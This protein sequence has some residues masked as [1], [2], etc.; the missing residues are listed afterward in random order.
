[1]E[2]STQT[3]E[4]WYQ[5]VVIDKEWGLSVRCGICQTP[6]T[7]NHEKHSFD[8]ACACN[9]NVELRGATLAERPSDRRERT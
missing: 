5:R 8:P 9:P 6:M 4:Q 2:P 1:M 7:P 3:I